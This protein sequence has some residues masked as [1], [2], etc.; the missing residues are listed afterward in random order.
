MGRKL[1]CT[2]LALMLAIPAFAG[3]D[4]LTLP[5][6]VTA[7]EESAFEDCATITEV[8]L[9]E[10]TAEIGKA[11][12]RGCTAL[13]RVSVPASLQSIGEDAFESCPADMLFSAATGSDAARWAMN[14]N[15]DFTAGTQYRALLIG[16]AYSGDSQLDGPPNDVAA[17][18]RC[19]QGFAGTPYAVTKKS[20]LDALEILDAIQSTFGQASENDVSLF[21]YSGH[22]WGSENTD[23]TDSEYQGALVGDDFAIITASRLRQ[24]M[25]KI[26]GR[27]ILII[28]SCFSGVHA[29]NAK[30]SRSAKSAADTAGNGSADD[31]VNS[32]ISAFSARKRG[33]GTY[34][35]YFIMA[36][37]GEYE[38]SW[39][40]EYGNSQYM[41]EFT[42]ALTTGSGSGSSL[43]AADRNMN[44]VITIQEAFQYA[45]SC[46]ASAQYPQHAKVYPA[47]CDWFGWLRK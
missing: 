31:F 41:G 9:P 17:M 39:E 47:G 46:V 13:S 40:Y 34:S 32:F 15:R 25:D 29:G 5:Q 19:L 10:G 11:A 43:G 33:N 42:R 4:S 3:A 12:F 26:P 35:S 37:A 23:Q 22:G 45:A 18:E 21:Y 44:S 28:D 38:L 24:A 16:Q 7:V 1:C 20:N 27:K 6:G 36:A 2:V 14:N 30:G 8:I